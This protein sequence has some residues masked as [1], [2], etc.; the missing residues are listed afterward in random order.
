M[1]YFNL[2]LLPSVRDSIDAASGGT[3]IHK[4]PSR[5]SKLVSRM[6]ENSQKFSSRT[7]DS[8]FSSTCDNFVKEQVHLITKLFASFVKGGS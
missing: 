5:A 7:L 3:L 1:E 4:T 6:A 8:N 2:R